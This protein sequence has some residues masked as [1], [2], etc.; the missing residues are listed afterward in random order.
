M[1][2]LLWCEE[3]LQID[4]SLLISSSDM[5]TKL[6]LKHFKHFYFY[7]TRL[8][9]AFI[10]II[11][12]FH[13]SGLTILHFYSWFCP[14]GDTEISGFSLTGP[15]SYALLLAVYFVPLCRPSRH[16]RTKAV[17]FRFQLWHLG[18]WF[19][20]VYL[21]LEE[22]PSILVKNKRAGE[23][24]KPKR[25]QRTNDRRGALIDSL[26]IFGVSC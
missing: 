22:L 16:P 11:L 19:G 9:K 8:F 7:S 4:F 18:E 5:L 3:D 17:V 23:T 14:G 20:N 2:K 21:H 26:L 15:T 6:L 25:T 13:W 10:I 24:Y 1:Q 12:G